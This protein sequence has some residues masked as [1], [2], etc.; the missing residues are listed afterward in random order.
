MSDISVDAL[1]SQMHKLAAL[2]SGQA[3]QTP[4]PGATGGQGDFGTLLKGLLDQVDQSQQTAGEMARSFE[5]DEGKFDLPEVMIAMQQARL[6][7]QTMLQVR[8]KVVQAY[9]DV[10]SMPV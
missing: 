7:F 1:L 5:A 9:Q 4:A 8:N 10:M 3:A 6:S 2:A